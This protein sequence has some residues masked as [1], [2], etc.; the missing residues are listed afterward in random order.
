MVG[1][2]VI[3]VIIAAV[4]IGRVLRRRRAAAY[5]LPTNANKILEEKVAFYRKLD[6]KNKAS[7][8]ARIRDFLAN[9][10]I[11]GVEVE[12]TDADKLLVA[13]GAIIPIFAFPDW[14]YNNIAEVL[15]YNDAFNE[16]YSTEGKGRNVLG[17]V[18]DGALHRN[19]ILSLPS[20]RASFQK[21][22]DGYNTALHEF[23]HL[24][25]KADGA[26]DGIPEYLLAE[27]A[28]RP[29]VRK[30]HAL[31]R[32]IRNGESTDINI[33]GAKNDAEFFAVVS[34]YF[35]ERP[36]K[37]KEH[38]PDLYAMLDKMFRPVQTGG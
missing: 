37:L 20:L 7:F 35:F 14:R 38:H 1:L 16:D 11:R 33:Y 31:I 10:N 6:S 12:I 27:Q 32:E 18:G 2:I 5:H 29:W 25:D 17:M 24:I 15:L 21:A 3:I 34:E 4:F 22:A 23:A 13:S 9:V 30:I 8:E 19:M 36:D 28:I 26:T